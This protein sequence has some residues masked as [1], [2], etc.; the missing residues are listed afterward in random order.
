[1]N[2]LELAPHCSIG[3]VALCAAVHFGWATPHV[4]IQENFADYDVPW[5]KDF[6]RGWNLCEGGEFKLPTEPGLGIELD[7]AVIAAHPPQK[8]PFPS[9]WDGRW[10]KDF[11][12][13]ND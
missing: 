10:L 2:E 8:N 13:K 1:M 6:V 4:R 7:P 5:R 12:R 3:P 11:T 9:L